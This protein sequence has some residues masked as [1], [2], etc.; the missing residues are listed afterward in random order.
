MANNGVGKISPSVLKIVSFVFFLVG[1]G[2]FFLKKSLKTF[3]PKICASQ[4]SAESVRLFRNAGQPEIEILTKQ[5]LLIEFWGGGSHEQERM[6]QC[7]FFFL[8]FEK[9]RI[10]FLDLIEANQ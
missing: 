2:R 3:A 7:R 5:R 6:R 10:H 8:L 9:R 4:D 1:G